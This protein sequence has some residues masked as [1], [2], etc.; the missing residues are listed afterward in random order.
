MLPLEGT[1]W[2]VVLINI[3]Y[4]ETLK[5]RVFILNVQFNCQ[6]LNEGYLNEMRVFYISCYFNEVA[7]NNLWVL[8]QTHSGFSWVVKWSQM[9]QQWCHNLL[10]TQN[11]EEVSPNWKLHPAG[12][13][14]RLC[15]IKLVGGSRTGSGRRRKR[16]R[17]L[18]QTSYYCVKAM[19]H[20]KRSDF[21]TPFIW[22]RLDVQRFSDNFAAKT[23]T[24]INFL[25]NSMANVRFIRRAKCDCHQSTWDEDGRDVQ[26]PAWETQHLHHCHL[27]LQ[28]T[29]L[30]TTNHWLLFMPVSAAWI[31]WMGKTFQ[32]TLERIC[33][34]QLSS[35]LCDLAA[36]TGAESIYSALN[37][38]YSRGCGDTQWT[39]CELHAK[40]SLA[41]QNA[42]M[43]RSLWATSFQIICSCSS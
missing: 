20:L 36:T 3:L 2:S 12:R 11:P 8:W 33:N 5:N 21:S 1:L 30:Q 10:R 9:K 39:N 42:P 4:V 23:T 6:Y 41:L 35:Y 26:H 22:T 13:K 17:F 27:Y 16:W 15:G 7:I 34:P 38:L 29:D 25:P 14:E 32:K 43:S 31:L 40:Q 18:T 19:L 28:W 37:F 24:T